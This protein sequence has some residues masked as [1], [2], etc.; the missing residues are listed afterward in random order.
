MYSANS[1]Q[2]FGLAI[3]STAIEE[4]D[5]VRISHGVRGVVALVNTHCRIS[6]SPFPACQAFA[7]NTM[8]IGNGAGLAQQWVC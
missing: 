2:S 3:G 1:G 8:I 6:P 4:A 5:H 7:H